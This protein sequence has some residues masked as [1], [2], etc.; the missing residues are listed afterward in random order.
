MCGV[1]GV[2]SY[3]DSGSAVEP[4]EVLRM[5]AHM[6]RRGPDGSGAWHAEDGRV[7]LAH[8]RLSIIDLSDDAAQPMT[9]PLTGAVITFNGEIY[10]YRTLRERLMAAGAVFRSSSDTEVLLQLYREKGPDM[11]SDLRGMFAFAIWDPQRQRLFCARDPYGI[12][13]L[14]YADDGKSLRFASQVKTLHASG[15]VSRSESAAGKTGFYL[16]GSMPE[17]WTW[18]E[19]IRAL[20]AGHCLLASKEGTVEVQAYDTLAGAWNN[21]EDAA[22]T[23]IPDA[24]RESV[25]AHLVSDVP[26]GLFL[27]GGID[28]G[29]LLALMTE[30]AGKPPQ[31]ITFGVDGPSRTADDESGRA[32]AMAR[33]HGAEHQVV[34]YTPEEIERLIPEF[35]SAMDQPSIDGLNTWLVSRAARAMG[36]KVVV[37][38][39]GGDELFGGY[40]SF[41]DIPNWVRMWGPL[42]LIQRGAGHTSSLLT[43]LGRLPVPPKAW[44]LPLLGGDWTS[45]YLLRRG[46]FMPWELSLIMNR[47][48]AKEG[49]RALCPMGS[50][51][52]VLGDL[53]GQH[54]SRQREHFARVAVLESTGYLK[55][56]LLRDADWAGMDN[57]IEIRTPL[58]D[59]RL[60]SQVAA[61]FP[62]KT[63]KDT[64]KQILA[65]AAEP[66]LPEE[67]VVHPKTGF[68]VPMDRWLEGSSVK[69]LWE[70]QTI[71]RRS[72][73][74]WSRRWLHT[75]AHS[76]SVG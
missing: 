21:T 45:A 29:A 34:R 2:F 51:E 15:R 61:N 19:A 50:T 64:G 75:V 54:M 70:G 60:L 53:D 7:A 48:E 49:L 62:E 8:R 12:K 13:P 14:Y 42:S 57:S 71:L 55:N 47:D 39:L 59:R 37:S 18:F 31:C 46:I 17:P 68:S 3:R 35:L 30:Q 28:S 22:H 69:P 72:R 65:S 67:V 9:D 10:N 56:Q 32:A 36:L 25:E 26:V 5:S 76:Y 40:P 74:H 16:W 38:G 43:G 63:A 11:L 41:T 58:V 27:S 33:L 23:S 73:C 1:A 4:E 66:P 20:P 44:G 52:R 24:L 6:A